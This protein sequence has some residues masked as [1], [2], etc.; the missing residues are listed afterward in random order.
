VLQPEFIVCDEITSALDVSTQAR[1]LALLDELR[2]EM[3]LSLLFISHDLHTV[4]K[5]SDYVHVMH[6]GR[7][8]EEGEPARIF[9][10]PAED[11]TRSLVAALPAG[12]PER[13]RFRRTRL[14]RES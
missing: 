2:A 9:G 3:N 6:R 14:A 13:R 5:V 8:V 11:Y 12:S 1:M 10:E 4:A 7:I